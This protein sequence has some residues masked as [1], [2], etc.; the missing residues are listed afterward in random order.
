MESQHPKLVLGSEDGIDSVNDLYK[1]CLEFYKAVLKTRS[2]IPDQIEREI[3]QKNVGRLFFWGNDF[4]IG[5]LGVILKQSEDLKIAVTRL[6]GTLA[7]AL[8]RSDHQ[9]HKSFHLLC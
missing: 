2:M 9:A 3:S 6:L 4:Q 1:D 8:L 5:K 7:K